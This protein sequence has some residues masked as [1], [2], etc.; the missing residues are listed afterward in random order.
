MKKSMFYW[1]V[2]GAV[3]TIVLG[4]FLHFLF[5]M[6]NRNVIAA[7]FSAVNESI[8]EHMK[9]LFYPM[10]L[11]A[12]IESKFIGNE[13]EQFWCVKLKGILE[14]LLLIPVF[15]YAYTGIL[16]IS[17]DWMNIAIFII[18]TV[19]VFWKEM[20]LFK[21]GRKCFF[22]DE[23]AVVCLCL[24]SIVFSVLTFSPLE[25]PLFEDPVTGNYGFYGL[26]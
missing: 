21:K 12:I 6:T 19:I 3:F 4:V 5:D 24:I 11:F 1:Q 2:I 8:W 9:L 20:R 17:A 23:K 25:I 22:D 13:Y 14:G 26:R 16:G 10:F 7:L 15:Y 18:S